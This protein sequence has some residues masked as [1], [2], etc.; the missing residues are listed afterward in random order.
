[1]SIAHPYAW[2]QGVLP[3]FALG[4]SNAPCV[5]GGHGVSA[6]A[7]LD[8]TKDASVPPCERTLDGC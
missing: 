6:D 3:S 4:M 1:M 5:R 7:W 2:N 8:P